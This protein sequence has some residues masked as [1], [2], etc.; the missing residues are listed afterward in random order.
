[1][2]NYTNKILDKDFRKKLRQNPSEQI[3]NFIDKNNTD[4]DVVIKTNTK[5]IIYVV[6]PSE[7]IITN[8]LQDINVAG[9][10]AGSTSTSSTLSSF[11]TAG[12]GTLSTFGCAGSLS[13]A[14]TVSG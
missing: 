9:A 3:N 2:E 4:F 13:T 7:S 11:G 5:D 8:N 6:F 10:T 1:M 14:G 12:G